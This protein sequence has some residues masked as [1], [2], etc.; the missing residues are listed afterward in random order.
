M[1]KA[2]ELLDHAAHLGFANAQYNLGKAYRDGAGVA[3][4]DATAL[5][6]FRAA[7]EQ[8]YAK[9]QQRLG[10]RYARGIGTAPDRVEALFWLRLAAR[11]G[12]VVAQ[13]DSLRLADHI[14]AEGRAEV[15]RRLATWQ[16]ITARQPLTLEMG[17]GL[18]SGPCVVG[19]MG[20]EQR[21][22][23]SVIGDP[24]NLASRLEGQT[25]NYGVGIVISES[26][27]ALA[28]EFAAL[29]LDLIAVKGKLEAVRIF[30]L[31][32]DSDYAASEAFRKLEDAHGGLLTAYR[33]QRWSVAQDLIV[34]CREL[35]PGLGELYDVYHDRIRRYE[36]EAPE[37]GWDGVYRATAK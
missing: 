14:D 34:P 22:D 9:A 6:W 13:E 30:A 16:P 8:D 20:S 23:Y 1:D 24:V 7:A 11:K 32:G 29:E 26:T 28:P 17:V 5:R 27:R 4:N 31:L 18:N 12:M 3:A 37:P 10:T 2:F 36:A 21:F 15:E 25:K 35:A 33:A 19:N